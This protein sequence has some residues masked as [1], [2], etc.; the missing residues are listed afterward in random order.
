MQ[1]N[2]EP[3][4]VNHHPFP[5]TTR[6][7]L[8]WSNTSDNLTSGQRFSSRMSHPAIAY[9]CKSIIRFSPHHIQDTCLG[10]ISPI[11]F[12]QVCKK[13]HETTGSQPPE[14][15]VTP[16]IFPSHQR[17]WRRLRYRLDSAVAWSSASSSA[18]SAASASQQRDQEKDKEKESGKKKKKKSS[19][20]E[21]TGNINSNHIKGTDASSSSS[22]SF[23]EPAIVICASAFGVE[24]ARPLPATFQMV[25]WL[26]RLF[27]FRL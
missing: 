10:R 3:P 23:R 21:D 20:G 6:G 18:S 11:I 2:N 12:H 15:V 9:F 22:S 4:L 19:Q 8:F 1:F 14:F 24:R 13:T 16:Y 17:L 7:I 26:A 5:T 25:R 27:P